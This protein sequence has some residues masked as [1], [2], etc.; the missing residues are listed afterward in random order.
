M[1]EFKWVRSE[2]VNSEVGPFTRH[3]FA[4]MEDGLQAQTLWATDESDN[5]EMQLL[6][7][8]G[9]DSNNKP[10]FVDVDPKDEQLADEFE[11][12]LKANYD[13]YTNPPYRKHEW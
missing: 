10:I 4:V 5:L 12:H 9:Q 6:L 13:V 7:Y 1:R 8:K 3:T 11:A 2:R